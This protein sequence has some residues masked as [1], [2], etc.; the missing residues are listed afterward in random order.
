[1]KNRFLLSVVD[2][3]G[4]R[5]FNIHKNAKKIFLA[6]T[7]GVVLM[8]GAGF[9]LM[10]Y[11][12][13]EIVDISHS[14]ETMLEKYRYIYAQNQTLKDRINLKSNELIE[15]SKKV[16]DLEEIV[17]LGKNTD[18][19]VASPVEIDSVSAFQKQI[20]L[21][22]IPNGN[23][24][25]DF[26]KIVSS[27]QRIHPLKNITGIA[28]GV[29]YIV[30]VDTPVYATADGIV[31]LVRNGNSGY[32]RFVKIVHSYGFSS[33]Y[34]HL[35]KIAVKRGAFV[36]K[37]QLLG[38][39]GN[40]GNSAGARLYYEIR[41]LG[42]YQ[43]AMDYIS[44]NGGNFESFFKNTAHIKWASLLWAIEDLS[45]LRTYRLDYQGKTDAGL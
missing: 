32:G 21:Q 25:Q 28:S 41:F 43:N 29:D 7:L 42:G 24:L 27:S 9:V 10:Y 12:M 14:K 15:V 37:G 26:T 13:G 38:Y 11:L 39:S 23:P 19:V 22:V 34:A 36:Q 33:M 4:S 40:S 44:W 45:Q 35:S 16:E 3:D 1:M 20:L 8:I 31:D 6:F 2:C 17:N 18:E 5:Q 30:A